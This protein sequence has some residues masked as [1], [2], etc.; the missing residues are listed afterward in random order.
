M[1]EFKNLKKKLLISEGKLNYK[2]RDDNISNKIK[3]N[4]DKS[5]LSFI[6]EKI[7]EKYKFFDEKKDFKLYVTK[8]DQAANSDTIFNRNFIN[9]TLK[10]IFSHVVST[11]CSKELRDHNK[12]V[13][14]TLLNDKD[15]EKRNYFNKIFNLKFIDALK[16]LRGET[17]GLEILEG[18]EFDKVFWNKIQK[19]EN[20][21]RYFILY[22]LCYEK[23]WEEKK[24]RNG[25]K[26][27]K[28]IINS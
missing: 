15:E 16:Y 7:K 19:N 11:K 20:Y 17:E 5:F 27:R 2:Y 6:N 28:K 1:L 22:M 25:K 21:S 8:H 18:L 26:R 9:M 13:I 4:V 24:P 12:D 10:E 3:S 23:L 14:N